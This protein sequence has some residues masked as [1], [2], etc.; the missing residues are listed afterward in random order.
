MRDGVLCRVLDTGR[1]VARV[2]QGKV[3]VQFLGCGLPP[4]QSVLFAPSKEP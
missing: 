2:R 1:Q 4:Y 3:T